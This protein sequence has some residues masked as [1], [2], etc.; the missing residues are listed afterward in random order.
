MNNEFG[1]FQTPPLLAQEIVKCLQTIGQW[2]F[3]IEPTCGTGNFIDVVLENTRNEQNKNLQIVGIERQENYV[4]TLNKKYHS[5]PNVK[6]FHKN[7]FDIYLKNDLNINFNNSVLVL[8]NPPWVTNAQLTVLTSDNI[9]IK[10]N[11]KGLKGIDALTGASNFDICEYIWLKL[12]HE[13][14]AFNPTI[15]LLCKLSVARNVIRYCYKNQLKTTESALF[16][17]DTKKWFNI[18]AEA[19]LYVLSLG[20]KN[21]IKETKVFNSVQDYKKHTFVLAFEQNHLVAQ[22]SGY[23]AVK[24]LE[25]KSKYVWRQGVKHDASMVVEITQKQDSFYNK[26]GEKV[27]VEKEYLF[28]YLKGAD[29]YNG[30][31]G[32]WLIFPPQSIHNN[33][34]H[35]AEEAP[36]LSSYLSAHE[37]YFTKRKSSIYKKA[38]RFAFFGVGTYTF[39][40]FKIA[41]AG[42]Y[43]EPVFQFLSPEDTVPIMVDDTCYFLPFFDYDEAQ[44]VYA[45]L[46]SDM[47]K[48]FIRAATFS[49]AKRP[50]TKT[51]LQRIC[52]EKLINPIKIP[53]TP[54]L[55]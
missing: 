41:I 18:S 15:A 19:C 38:N 22:T 39:A 43:K 11:V 31:R 4:A 54:T 33:I 51:L 53:L 1:D 3:I 21:T 42:M 37:S 27:V 26:L 48:N 50:I 23:E 35:L 17:I 55:F 5:L 34:L 44:L 40:P 10:S 52:V 2:D 49:D 24:F 9:P 13:L 12:I 36:L 29:V 30:R 8:G 25:G 6:I 32:K 28:P 46:N 45:A 20:G 16:K 14:L 7:L 47:V